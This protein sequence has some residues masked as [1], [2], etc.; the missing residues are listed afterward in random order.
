V[1]C[2]ASGHLTEE[3]GFIVGADETERFPFAQRNQFHP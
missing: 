2:E 3:K 1:D